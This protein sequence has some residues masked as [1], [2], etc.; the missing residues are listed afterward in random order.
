MT[1]IMLTKNFSTLQSEVAKH[2]AADQVIQDRYWDD[3][4]QNGCF[5]GCL[6][7]SDDA[8]LLETKYGIPLMLVRIAESIF[9]GLSSKKAVEFFK[10]FPKAVA[11]N[12]KDLSLVSWKF[13]QFELE[14][15]P[16]KT[17]LV[18]DVIDGISKLAR[19]EKWGKDEARA[20]EF[21]AARAADAAVRAADDA[22]RAADDAAA[23]DWAATAADRAADAAADRAAWFGKHDHRK[24]QAKTLLR[25]IKKAPVITEDN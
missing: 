11:C 19:G 5:I 20:A 8:S 4:E 6:A 24:Q 13:L 3:E 15:L 18:Q 16:Y 14:N 21:A 17:E 7:H 9:E 1:T 25:L 22:V 12:N 2:V 10:K 23:A